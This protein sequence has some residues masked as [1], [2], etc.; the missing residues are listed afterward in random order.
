MAW[1]K[2]TLNIDA[3]LFKFSRCIAYKYVVHSPKRNTHPWEVLQDAPRKLPKINRCLMVPSEKGIVRRKCVHTYKQCQIL[4]IGDSR[5]FATG[6]PKALRWWVT[7][8]LIYLYSEVFQHLTFKNSCLQLNIDYYVAPT[9]SLKLGIPN[10]SYQLD[11]TSLKIFHLAT[12]VCCSCQMFSTLSTIE[13]S[14]WRKNIILRIYWKFPLVAVTWLLQQVR[15]KAY[16][17]DFSLLM[18]FQPSNITSVQLLLLR[19]L[20]YL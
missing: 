18:S 20:G 16:V 14:I 8:Q 5:I 17:N 15:P 9:S 2:C 7:L 4:F 13:N 3:E 1:M 10:S 6:K 19:Y 12:K 11:H